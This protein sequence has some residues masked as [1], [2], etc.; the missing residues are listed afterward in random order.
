MFSGT[1]LHGLHANSFCGLVGQ[2]GGKGDAVVHRPLEITPVVVGDGLHHSH[3]I[4][5]GAVDGGI[6]DDIAWLPDF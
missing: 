5:A 6:G 2:T 4:G 3:L 1:F